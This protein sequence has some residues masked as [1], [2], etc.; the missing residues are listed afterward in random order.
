[1]TEQPTPEQVREITCG[2]CKAWEPNGTRYGGVCGEPS[3]DCFGISVSVFKPACPAL[4]AHE[5][6]G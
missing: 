5:G 6:E 2:D 4:R 1:M 3:A